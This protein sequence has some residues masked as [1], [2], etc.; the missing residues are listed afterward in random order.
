MA[1]RVRKMDQLSWSLQ[2]GTNQLYVTS[3]GGHMAPVIFDQNSTQPIEPYFV[4]P[5]HGEE[6]ELDET[7][8][9][10]LRG[11]FF[12]LPFGENNAV[13]GEFHHVHGETAG[14]EWEFVALT[15]EDGVSTIELAMT[16][17]ERPGKVTKKLSF[18]EGQTAVYQQH[19]IEGFAGKTTLGH[20][21]TLTGEKH[22]NISTSPLHFGRVNSDAPLMVNR[23][24]ISLQPGAWFEM[25]EEVPTVWKE[26]A[27]TDCSIFPNQEGFVDIIQVFFQPQDEEPVWT[28]AVCEEE[29]FL[30]Y[31]FKNHAVLPSMVMWMEN[32]GRHGAPWNGRNCCI[33]L[34]DVCA[35]FAKGLVESIA[36]NDISKAG[37]PTCH[38]LD[39]EG[40]TVNVVQ[41]VVRV[42]EG[43]DKVKKIFFEDGQCTFISESDKLVATRV[44]Y[45]FVFTGTL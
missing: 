35:Y 2:N 42:P 43:F 37:I 17:K 31:S 27:V 16:I 44:N 40:F 36:E 10:P 26:P 33:G 23:E 39:G 4:N 11:D 19:H 12:C 34:E 24:Y 25:L 5:W 45:P 30:W 15:E 32:H 41:G 8:L 18:V 29:G 20:H 9:V 21:A 38:E 22:W 1:R 6:L 28:C 13:N 14:N 3:L 7:V